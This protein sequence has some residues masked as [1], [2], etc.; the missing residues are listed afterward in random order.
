[1]L[2]ESD[3][4]DVVGVQEGIWRCNICFE[5]VPGTHCL[6]AASCTHFFCLDC[7][8]SHCQTQLK[9]KRLDMMLC[10]QHGCKQ[11]LNRAVMAPCDAHT[12]VTLPTAF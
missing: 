3:S 11:P 9:D 2:E 5:E 7:L 10:P 6:R 12:H 8:H 4:F 1:M